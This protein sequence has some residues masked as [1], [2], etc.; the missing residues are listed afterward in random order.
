MDREVQMT[1]ELI[2][3]VSDKFSLEIVFILDLTGANIR[4]ITGLDQ[5]INLLVL[6]LS[7][8]KISR[9]RGLATCIEL[10]TL[11]LSFNE[12]GKIEG[13]RTLAKLEKLDLSSN[14]IS[15]LS[16]INDLQVLPKLR[17]LNFQQFDL[18]DSNPI[19]SQADYR[20]NVLS[21]LPQIISL[22]SH[23]KKVNVILREDLSKYEVSLKGVKLNMDNKPWISGSFMKE[24][25]FSIEDNEIKSLIRE[26]KSLLSK[27]DSI[28]NG[29]R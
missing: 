20:S 7:H 27:G 10:V 18:N 9:I 15:N 6:N 28:L 1:P 25:K 22:D 19:C 2:K 16:G 14:R 29:V 4:E 24:D 12:I 3:S 11:D 8:N 26:C 13:L 5:C 23:R 21:L 17:C